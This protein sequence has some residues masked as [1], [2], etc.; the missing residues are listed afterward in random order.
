[1]MKYKSL[2]PLLLVIGAL[3]YFMFFRSS[4]SEAS[5]LLLNGVVYTVDD[6]QPYAEAVAIMDD[7]IVGVGTTAGIQARFRS[8]RVIDLAGKPVFPGFIDSHAHIEGLGSLLMNLDL[9]QTRS[10][11]QIQELVRRRVSEVQPGIWV[12]G[13]GWDQNRWEVKEFPT[14]E[15]LDVVAPNVPVYLNRIDGHAVWVNKRVLEIA[16]VTA[17]TPDPEGGLVVRDDSGEPTGIFVD[18]AVDMLDAALPDPSEA[19][20]TEAIERAVHAC[21]RVGLTGVHDMGMDREG[22]EIYKKLIGSGR[23][24]FRVYVAV[25]APGATW[26]HYYERGPEIGGYDGKLTV[27]ALKMYADGAL[28]S[29]GGA[30]IEPYSDNPA[31]RGLTRT[32]K[33]SMMYYGK[34]AMEKGFQV[35]IHAI[36][37]RANH[38]VLNVYEELAKLN[39][40]QTTNA[41]LRIEH[42][43]VIAPED[44]S[45]FHQLGVLPMMQ[46][47]HCT[48]DMP[49]VT[50]RLGP[51]RVKGAYAWRSLIDTGCIVPAGSDFPVESNNPLWGFYAAI[52]RQD[53]DGWP[54]GGWHPEQRMSREEALKAMTIWAATAAFEEDIKGTIEKEKLA[55]LVVLSGDIMQIP[56]RD[57]LRTTVA[58]TIVGGEVVYSSDAIAVREH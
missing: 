8:S 50:R 6:R 36:G 48:S 49:W 18:R 11:E 57:I 23:F 42:A 15:V 3:L 5:L 24:P 58:I 17:R 28:G 30:L 52:T 26:D 13:R 35:C 43:Q 55:D 22:I 54:Q 25:D 45:R 29:W 56:P 20:R 47:T 12:R 53:H 9:T 14:H 32:S 4:V 7:K 44:I 51:E 39:R 2:I 10:L 21:V 37:D 40:E 33:D 27:R 31:T 16:G 1:M 38:V 41:R 46:P 34:Q 19:E